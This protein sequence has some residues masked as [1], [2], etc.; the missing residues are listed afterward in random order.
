MEVF[1]TDERTGEK[2]LVH[3]S[4]PCAECGQPLDGVVIPK[5]TRQVHAVC[6]PEGRRG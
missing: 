2:I 1:K 5:G 3:T 6:P 4:R